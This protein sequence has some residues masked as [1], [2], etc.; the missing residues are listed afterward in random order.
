MTLPVLSIFHPTDVLSTAVSPI[1]TL[2]ARHVQPTAC[3]PY[4]C[5]GSYFYFH[6]RASSNTLPVSLRDHCVPV[7]RPLNQQSDFHEIWY[8]YYATGRHPML[9]LSTLGGT[10]DFIDWYIICDWI[11]APL[12]LP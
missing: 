11:L 5:R 7:C 12:L 2:W 10:R 1:T 3:G 9:F 8:E 4:V 6:L